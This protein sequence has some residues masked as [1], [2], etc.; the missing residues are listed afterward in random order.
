MDD[1]LPVRKN[2]RLGDYDYSSPGYYFVT[3]CSKNHECLFGEIIEQKIYLSDYG[4]IAESEL[5]NIP[6]HY[7]N[8]QVDKH[9]IMPNHIHL[10]IVV[11]PPL[12]SSENISG[13]ASAPL[14]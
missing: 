13:R 11:E 10:I 9:I 7:D 8:I 4:K 5:L 6:K 1:K 2:V 14:Q 12:I 3:I